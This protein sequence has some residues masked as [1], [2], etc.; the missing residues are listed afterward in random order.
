[1]TSTRLLVRAFELLTSTPYRRAK[2]K[3]Q[4]E[5]R[6]RTGNPNIQAGATRIA[7]AGYRRR[8]IVLHSTGKDDLEHLE[9]DQTIFRRRLE[10][11]IA[12][13][14]QLQKTS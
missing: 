9:N 1:M 10:D 12:H 5:W 6:I 4:R 3:T 13:L 14:L 11:G 7:Q 2:K 8:L